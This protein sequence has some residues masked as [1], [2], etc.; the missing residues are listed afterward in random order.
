[1]GKASRKK[2]EKKPVQ[3]NKPPVP[4][5]TFNLTGVHPRLGFYIFIVL[6][7]IFGMLAY[8]NT[9]HAPFQWDE[10][11][12]IEK[13]PIVKDL[14][15]FLETSKAKGFEGY[16]A[17]QGRYIGYLTFAL[18][19]KMHGLD[20][21]G[22]HVVNVVIH[23]LNALLVYLLVALT[24]KTPF[25]MESSLSYYSKVIAFFT[26]MLFVSHPVQTEAVTYIFQR[27]A[28]LVTLFYM[29]SLVCY[30]KARL[31]EQAEVKVEVENRTKCNKYLSSIF[32]FTSTSTFFVFLSVLFAVLAMKTKENAFT[33]PIIL[34][35][36]EF[37]FFRGETRQR[38]LRLIPIL[39][40]LLII[41]MTQ[42]G[43]AD[44]IGG[45]AEEG[46][47][48][49]PVMG[50]HEH[51]SQHE[52]L[53]TQLR[54]IVTYIRLLFFPV[55][56]NLYYDYP[57]F[58]SFFNP[59]VFLSFLFLL[60]ILVFAVY[61]FRRSRVTGHESRLM[62]F[63]ILWFFVALS[64]ESSIIP[65]PMIICEYRVYLPSAGAFLA[66]TTG[67]FIL[68]DKVK[69]KKIRIAIISSLILMTFVFSYAA[70]ARNTLWGSNISLWEDVVKK[71]PQKA[72]GYN[73]L[74]NAY[75]DKGQIDTAISY[76]HS[77]LKVQP[78]HAKVYYNL[79]NAYYG[80]GLIDNAIGHY[81]A[82]IRLNP[83]YADAH[84]NLGIAYASKDQTDMAIK[85][86]ETAIRLKP[87]HAETYYN[88]GVSY[89]RKGLTD[90]AIGQLQTAIKLQPD[91]AEAYN[92][93]G[94]IYGSK[95]LTDIAIDHYE[96]AL[97]LKPGYAET[98][99]N[100]GIAYSDKGLHGKATEHF[101]AAIKLN[102]AY[103]SAY[104]NF[105][106]APK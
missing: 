19:Y 51:M 73:T 71:S 27:L 102:P 47:P 3:E 58:R 81:Q 52:Y 85:H 56:Q 10:S 64:V 15:Y 65:I 92:N 28:S 83:R 37:S 72:K 4:E 8:S 74:G 30:I 23:I 78:H 79:G 9:F 95:G 34:T 103:L 88:L 20:V 2:K 77:A 93:L 6:I 90:K 7:P 42:T 57:V 82:A 16:S 44:T 105:R 55:N 5:T 33:L 62:A 50:G 18:N 94:A 26:A 43:L 101:Q 69:D 61:L 12:Y 106:S 89:Y 1:M 11:A 22:Y 97:E 31:E 36:Y 32:T 59:E 49:T 60:S 86:Y 21:T 98:H 76:Y 39:L 41:P 45:P 35:L 14:S 29:L 63:G 96:A 53:L 87:E 75:Y 54:V 91:Y 100:L 68:M 24:F 40:T 38:M 70:Y 66:I 80:K 99:Y 48:T 84:N 46:P 17:L 67:L 104:N 13:N 25:M